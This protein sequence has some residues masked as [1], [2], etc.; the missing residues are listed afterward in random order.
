MGIS[1]RLRGRGKMKKIK[2]RYQFNHLAIFISLLWMTLDAGWNT[3]LVFNIFVLV[4]L[5]IEGIH[6][7]FMIFGIPISIS[8]NKL[9]RNYL[10]FK[11]S[12]LITEETKF[13][14]STLF[15]L[16][17]GKEILTIETN[18]RRIKILDNY[19]ISVRDIEAIFRNSL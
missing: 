19:R 18:N 11:K 16:S 7:L 15:G 4:F 17:F 1:T 12:I 6:N 5:V 9:T 10:V 13:S 3:L 8:E 14:Y 2:Y